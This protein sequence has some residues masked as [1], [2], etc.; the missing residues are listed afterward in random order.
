MTLQ[1]SYEKSC[2]VLLT[3]KY[4]NRVLKGVQTKRRIFGSP[5]DLLKNYDR[6]DVELD[7]YEAVNQ[8]LR[9]LEER[10][11]ITV[12]RERHQTTVKRYALRIEAVPEIEKHLKDQYGLT[13]SAAVRHDME[14]FLQQD[15]SGAGP[16]SFYSRRLAE[17]MKNGTPQDPMHEK[18][19]IRTLRF[20]Q[21]NSQD[22]YLREASMF[23]F[24]T[25]KHLEEP[26]LLNAVCMALRDYQDYQK[27]GSQN[28]AK[29]GDN[30]GSGS[31]EIGN[32]GTESDVEAGEDDEELLEQYHIFRTDREIRVRG[33]LV[34]EWRN[35]NTTDGSVFSN[36]VVISSEDEAAI[37]AVRTTARKLITIENKTAFQRYRDPEAL[38][39]YLGGFADRHQIF[40]LKRIVRENPQLELFHFGDID[41]G[42]FRIHKN[43][44]EMTGMHFTP[45]HMGIDELKDPEYAGSLQPLTPTDRRNARGLLEVR[46]YREV[47]EY[48][49][50]HNVKLEQE[51]IAYHLSQ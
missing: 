36:G 37:S 17:R 40:F 29:S 39:V 1:E 8:A 38:T 9:S 14:E 11:W 43:I 44:C 10:G 4:E 32:G 31:N 34:I 6:N 7:Q 45:W 42:G 30:A 47:I 25:S 20:L 26:S 51:I 2:L 19:I 21:A 33:P 16:A 13:P 3:D 24:G 22:L 50:D 18:E 48:M 49:L 12:D 23:L 35:G 46:E 41:V 5:K 28:N 15:L 27:R